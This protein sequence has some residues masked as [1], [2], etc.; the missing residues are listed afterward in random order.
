MIAF[1][2]AITQ[3][4]IDEVEANITGQG[5]IANARRLSLAWLKFDSVELLERARRAA[6]AETDDPENPLVTAL[7][8]A[9]DFVDHTRSTLELAEA[10]FSRMILAAQEIA[11][12]KNDGG[13]RA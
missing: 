9:K 2:S 12:Q 8:M 1:D 13:Q 6:N 11:A 4:M 5:Y 10:A 7:K 3:K